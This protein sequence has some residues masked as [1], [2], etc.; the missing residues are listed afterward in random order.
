LTDAPFCGTAHEDP[1][2]KLHEECG[3]FAL[4]G[5]PEAA[6]LIYLGL[7]ALQHRGQ[8]SAGMATSDR[9]KIHSVRSM[10]HVADIFRPEVLNQLP[11]ALGIGHTR[12]STAGDTSLKNA[13]PL[14]VACSKGQV[15]VA[16][17]GNLTNAIEL[18]RDLEADGSIFQSTSDTEVILHLVA[19]S[20]ERTLAGALRDALL[21][22]EGAFSLVFLAE[23]RVIVARDPYGFRPLAMGRLELPDGTVATVFASETCAFDLIN[24]TYVGE[25]EPG[26][27][28]I[29]GPEG[30][31]RE[32]YTPPQAPSHCAFEHV[33]FSRPDSTVFGKPVAQTRELMGRL[34]ARE[35]HVDADV[36]VPVPDSGVIAAIGY[37]AE[38]GIP[39]RQGLIRNH[40]V[41]RTFIE[42]SQAIRDFGVKLKLNPVRHILEG[43]RVIL[44]DDSIVRG[45]T[46]RKIVR[47]VRS[48]GASE[49]HVRI[50]CPPTISPCYYGVDTPSE[51]ELIAAN[52]D[53]EQIR[54]Y[55]EA[56]SI[57]YL[58]LEC[59]QTALADHD[60]HFCYSCYTG[61][62]PT[63]VQIGEIVLAKTG[64]C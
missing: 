35:H 46:S 23:D 40:Y 4:Y 24:A 26:E 62:Y 50:S 61:K 49:V 15:A 12:Y 55:V 6:N 25:V 48:A 16:H 64:C 3:V 58:S 59:L 51:R 30:M 32:L 1:F 54:E 28:V 19:R 53:L 7:Y 31:T 44:V 56:D 8:E 11:G 57:G 41:G 5:H 10:G 18:R 39:Y 60:H 9:R 14:S 29:I 33:Y 17:N 52:N 22:I 27:M 43:K 20:R 21:Q 63:L 37:S 13:Q 45:T 34:L 2:D 38:S 36:I 47:M 42:P